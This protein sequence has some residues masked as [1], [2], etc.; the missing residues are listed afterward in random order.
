VL[1]VAL[2]GTALSGAEQPAD[3]FFQTHR[4]ARQALASG[5]DPAAGEPAGS[6]KAA[7]LY[8]R[9]IT[10]NPDSLEAAL[11]RVLRGIILW[12]DEQQIGPAEKDFR[13]AAALPGKD[14]AAVV[15]NLGKRW[16][17]RVRMARIVK[18]CRDY[19]IEEVEYPGR[20]RQLVESK[21]IPEAYLRDPWND[22]FVYEATQ[23]RLLRGIPRQ[24]YEL[25]CKSMLDGPGKAQETLENEKAFCETL[26]LKGTNS[27]EPR[28]V[29]VAVDNKTHIIKQG[30]T[31]AGLA[32]VL[33][34]SGRAVLCSDDYLVVLSR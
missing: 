3:D 17:A 11:C 1:W 15:A 5:A 22:P 21:L 18:A 34:E 28:S 33:I 4:L 2:A 31:Q 12:R 19:Y 27:E 7:E 9:F 24:K 10:Q 8:G 16:L 32:P 25:L 30:E 20:L 6:R 29:M 26:S 23:H 14:A 13:A